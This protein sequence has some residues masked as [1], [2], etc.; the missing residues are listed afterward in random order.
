MNINYHFFSQ[1]AEEQR[2]NLLY[3]SLLELRSHHPVPDAALPLLLCILNISN[4]VK[5]ASEK[6]QKGIK[7]T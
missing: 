5:E 1:K 2:K 4:S 6:I 7:I 3:S